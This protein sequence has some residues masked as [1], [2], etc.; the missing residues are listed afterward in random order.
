[1]PSDLPLITAPFFCSFCPKPSYTIMDPFMVLFFIATKPSK[2][3]AQHY[4]GT[5]GTGVQGREAVVPMTR[6]IIRQAGTC[7]CVI[8]TILGNAIHSRH[9]LSNYEHLWPLIVQYQSPLF[10]PALSKVLTTLIS[11]AGFINTALSPLF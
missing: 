7:S 4:L 2:L 5:R 9:N 10:E 11:R 8:D 3:H 6:L 1:V